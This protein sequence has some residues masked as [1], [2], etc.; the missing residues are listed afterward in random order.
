MYNIYKDLSELRY[1]L[2]RKDKLKF[3][4]LFGLMFLG[5]LLEAVGI[6]VIPIFVSVIMQPSS[7]SENRWVGDWFSGLPNEPTVE[8]VFWASGFLL[9]FVILKNIFLIFVS[10]VQAGV[11]ASQR[12]KLGDRLFKTYQSAPYE[13][14]LQRSS[15]ELLRNIQND[16]AQILN[17]VV[18]PVLTLIMGT[19]MM[20]LIIIVLVLNT[21]GLAL[22]SVLVTGGGLAVVVIAFHKQL[23]HIGEVNRHAVKEMFKAIQQGFGALVDARIAG[24]EGYLNKVHRFS[25]AQICKAEKLLVTIQRSTPYILEV[26]TVF[27]LLIILILLVKISE[28]LGAVLPV[29]AM[30]GVATIRLK[31][32]ASQISAA[33]NRI[34][35]SR[36]YIPG[37]VKDLRE[38]D[39]VAHQ[40]SSVEIAGNLSLSNVESLR[41]DKIH[42]AYPGAK[43]SAIKGISLELKQGESIAFVGS[44]GCG[45]STLVNI[46]LGLLKPTSGQI[47][48]NGQDIH[49]N[50]RVWQ[51]CIGYIPQSIYLID[52]T[53][54]ANIAFGIPSNNIN[55]EQL[56][57]AL[58]SAKLD[59]FILTLPQGLDTVI[60][61]HGVRLSGGQR[62]RL[63]IARALYQDPKVLVMDEA[64]SA[65]DN[66][67][68]IEVM[69]AVKNLKKG[70]ILIM[71]AHRLST[72][73]DC[74]R[75]Y[76]LNEGKIES[77]GTYSE[78]MQKSTA[79]RRMATGNDV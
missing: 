34:N 29:I 68:E 37:I 78:L 30:L 25:L 67:T 39:A 72:V 42:Y 45:K 12:L 79:F 13:W 55:E 23:R 3:I 27:G 64:T 62:Q 5:G 10:Y 58:R 61:E 57:S 16:T 51:T 77:F 48:V 19:V 65:L 69:Q 2:T 35:A 28:S 44:T 60:G 56:T 50:I 31:A 54:K 8:L 11:V 47:V 59:D 46:I 17:G 22:L 14:H 41:L 63:G 49:E 70:R 1:L 74:E 4:A 53:I 76:F 33:I 75:L 38:L 26:I 18:M 7:L 24:C 9:G 40:K 52:D 43:K 32:V 6:G 73:E 71:I 21:P 20:L 66:K 36:V 15:S